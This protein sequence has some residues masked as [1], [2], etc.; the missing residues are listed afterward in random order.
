MI[1]CF[2]LEN[3]QKHCVYSLFVTFR[4]CW[5]RNITSETLK[6]MICLAKHVFLRFRFPPFPLE[7]QMLE[8]HI[9][10]PSM[11]VLLASGILDTFP[12]SKLHFQPQA[13]NCKG[14]RF[15][16]I[17]YKYIYEGIHL[18]IYLSFKTCPGISGYRKSAPPKE[19]TPE[20]YFPPQHLTL[21]ATKSLTQ[22]KGEK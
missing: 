13:L 2:S 8:T 6:A 11:L 3:R 19:I 9:K 10:T 14:F 5:K 1:Y 22:T 16:E 7:T 12:L 15:P 18:H 20:F 21:R 4:E 17:I